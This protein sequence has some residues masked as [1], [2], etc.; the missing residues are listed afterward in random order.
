MAIETVKLELIED[1]PYQPRHT[2]HPK[3]IE[4]LAASIKVNGLL[5]VPVARRVDGKVQLGFGHLRKRAFLKLAKENPKKWDAMPL[6]IRELTDKQMA[7]F[8]L[9]ENIKRRDITPIEVARAV[10]SYLIAFTDASEQDLAKT[11]N[12]SQGN[13]S[14]MRRVLKLPEQVLEKIDEGKINFTQGRELL[15]FQ[16]VTCHTSNEKD[17]MLEAIRGLKSEKKP[18]GEPNTVEGLQKS[19]NSVARSH[20]YALE[21]GGGYYYTGRDPLFDTRAAGCLKCEHMIL[22]HPTKSQASHFCANEECWEKHQKDHKDQ[23]AA[24][25]RAKMTQD[26]LQKVAAVEIKRQAGK[27]ISQEIAAAGESSEETLTDE[28]L[29][30]YSETIERESDEKEEERDRLESAK[31]LPANWPCHGCINVARCERTTVH[32]G[33]NPNEL[34]CE[35]RVTKET[36]PELKQKATV[37]IPPELRK[38]VQKKAGTRA[39]VLDLNQL[40]LGGYRQ[41]LKQGYALL[42]DLGRIDDPDECMERCTEGFHY[43]FDSRQVDGTVRYVCTNPKCLSQKKAAFTRAKNAQ[44]QAKKKA[45]LAAIKQAVQETTRLDMPRMKLIVKA[46]IE[47]DESHGYHFGMVSTREQSPKM[48]WANKLKIS[49]KSSERAKPEAIYAAL[50]KLSEEELAKLIVESML[51]FLTYEGGLETYRIQTEVLNWMGIGIN[52]I[53]ETYRIQTTEVLN[54][55]G[56]GINI[57]QPKREKKSESEKRE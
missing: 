33:D 9:E 38:L 44:A 31:S 22:T 7:A 1:N 53:L 54:W 6:D 30:A 13:I 15:I 8:A 4:D 55:M 50:N 20:M 36:V 10:D 12:M 39:D 16:G 23:A 57:E 37:E 21:R 34:I 35:N 28:Q 49:I 5:Q 27:D 48:W 41:E 40:W 56:I 11:L 25:A 17:L 51:V 24:Q 42:D 43:A 47:K 26:V 18:Y 29:D 19:I 14:N 2:Y 32:A 46:Q 45:E 52:T 3:D